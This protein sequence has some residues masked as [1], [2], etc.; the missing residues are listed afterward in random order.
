VPIQTSATVPAAVAI[1]NPPGGSVSFS[2]FSIGDNGQL[3]GDGIWAVATPLTLA[4]NLIT[5]TGY[6]AGIRILGSLG[7][8]LDHNDILGGSGGG[9]ASILFDSQVYDGGASC[10]VYINDLFTNNHGI[11]FMGPGGNGQGNVYN[12]ISISDWLQENEDPTD[13]GMIQVDSGPNAPGQYNAAGFPISYIGLLNVSNSDVAAQY[14]N[15]FSFPGTST[16][17]VQNISL[18]NVQNG[19]SLAVCVNGATVCP[20]ALTNLFTNNGPPTL[21]A[22]MGSSGFAQDRS[23]GLPTTNAANVSLGPTL[24]AQTFT[25]GGSYAIPAWAM[26]MPAPNSLAVTGTGSGS[27]S[28]GTYCL[29]ITGVDAQPSGI[30]QTNLSNVVCQAVGASGSI[31][32]SWLEGSSDSL[33]TAFSNFDLWYCLESSGPCTP[34]NFEANI[35][36]AGLDPVTATFSSTAGSI[37]GTP[38]ANSTAQFSWLSWDWNQT[39]YSCFFC[40]ARGHSDYWPVGFGMVPTGNAGYN[41]YTKLGV[42]VGTTLRSA[43]VSTAKANGVVYVDG[44]TYACSDV[45]INAAIAALGAAGGTVDAGACTSAGTIASPIVVGANTGSASV[46]VKL[47]LP[48]TSSA[49]NVTITGGTHVFRIADRSELAGCA[50]RA[51]LIFMA[52]S[53]SPSVLDVISFLPNPG[54]SNIT[55]YAKVSN[56]WVENDNSSA[57]ITNGLLNLQNAYDTTI[58]DVKLAG[59]APCLFYAADTSST[60]APNSDDIE[61]LLLDGLKTSGTQLVCIESNNGGMV[62]PIHFRGGDWGHPG[63]GKNSVVINRS[64]GGTSH[65]YGISISDLYMETNSTDTSTATISAADTVSLSLKNVWVTRLNGSST[66]ACI[67]VSDSG[68]GQTSAITL[69]NFECTGGTGNNAVVS[70]VSGIPSLAVAQVPLYSSSG[71]G[72]TNSLSSL[73]G[74]ANLSALET[75]APSGATNVDV[76]Y[77]DSTAHQWKKIE[78][79]GAAFA[80][81]GTLAGVSGSIGGSAL[82]AGQCAGGT[83]SVTN[84]TTGMSVSV[85]PNTYP[86]DGFIPWGYVSAAGVVTVKV[87]A[88]ASGTPTSS[89]YNVRAIQ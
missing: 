3:A 48:C 33:N 24:F 74:L 34:N 51:S 21:S 7:V 46:G 81:A 53:G 9:L 56:V 17:P 84:A 44:V 77:A 69:Q 6:G 45:G 85:S 47:I 75:T 19:G 58:R 16:S 40:T 80:V 57:T 15:V 70:T 31:A 11:G 79:N 62:G 18:V 59:Q 30:G 26:V 83:V 23:Y 12:T 68:S 5:V 20:V 89:T 22:G 88:Q 25:G 35:S 67:A 32:L 54:N 76:L 43:A 37:P 41:I 27:L 42:N 60:I 61:N 2:N 73:N 55:E 28:A 82:T 1:V 63:S 86:G 4:N 72:G 38:N 8:H 10:C 71:L 49:W 78:N 29:G 36:T 65:S 87:C 13:N 50:N 64:G 39:P 52:S 66:A 14:Q